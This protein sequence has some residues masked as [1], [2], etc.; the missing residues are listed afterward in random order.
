M[1]VFALFYQPPV[2]RTAAE[3]LAAARFLFQHRIR[4]QFFRAL[5]FDRVHELCGVMGAL[6]CGEGHVVFDVGV[7]SACFPSVVSRD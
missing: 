3:V 4:F 7:S 5:G 1:R 2:K 6:V